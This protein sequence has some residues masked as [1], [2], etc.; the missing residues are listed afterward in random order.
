M[1]RAKIRIVRYYCCIINDSKELNWLRILTCF[2]VTS[3]G[4]S[5][6]QIKLRGDGASSFTLQSN[7]GVNFS[8]LNN[9]LKK[10]Q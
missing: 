9:I 5:F 10:N 3:G 4:Y 2:S 6:R 8:V 1:P 7:S